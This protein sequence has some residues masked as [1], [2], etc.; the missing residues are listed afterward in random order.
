MVKSEL[1][2]KLKEFRIALSSLGVKR[3]T[4]VRRLVKVLD[5]NRNALPGDRDVSAECPILGKRRV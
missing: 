1:N 4:S 2:N 5:R 3:D